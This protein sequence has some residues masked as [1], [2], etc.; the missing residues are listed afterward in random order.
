MLNEKKSLVRLS[1]SEMKSVLGGKLENTWL[2]DCGSGTMMD[3]YGTNAFEA[4]G[5]YL[6]TGVCGGSSGATCV[7]DTTEA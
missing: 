5:N 3:V 2:C 6:D 7:R 1:R 4:M